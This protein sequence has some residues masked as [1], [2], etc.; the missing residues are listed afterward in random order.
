MTRFKLHL[1]FL[2]IITRER[3]NLKGLIH[4][5][6]EREYPKGRRDR[7]I[8]QNYTHSLLLMPRSL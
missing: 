4:E 5:D 7:S 1:I 3:M 8:C 2:G 6:E